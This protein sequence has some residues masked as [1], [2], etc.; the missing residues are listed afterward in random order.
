[1]RFP[2]DV[3]KGIRFPHK[4]IQWIRSCITS[5]SFSICVIGKLRG[6][7]KG[8]R[9]LRQGE[10]L[11]LYLFVIVIVILARR[12]AEKAATP[13]FKFHWR[14]KK[15][16]IINLC[17]ADD[18]MIFCKGDSQCVRLIKEAITKFQSLSGLTPSPNKSHM[19]FS[20]MDC[21]MRNELLSIMGF[22]DG[23]L[24]V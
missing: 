23:K 5:P 3:L 20:R 10:Q 22:N 4:M 7:F 9:G 1:M 19:F 15:N 2:F 6:Y 14:C 16:K 18:L 12:L 21:H 8:A 24:P 13:S 11:Y 17:F